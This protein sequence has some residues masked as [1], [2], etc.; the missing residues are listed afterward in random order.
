[1][2]QVSKQHLDGPFHKNDQHPMILNI[3]MVVTISQ[4]LS[5]L[6][7]FFF[8]CFGTFLFSH[9]PSFS[10]SAYQASILRVKSVIIA[11]ELQQHAENK[12]KRRICREWERSSEKEK[13]KIH[14]KI[15][16][17]AIFAH[18]PH[19][20][21]GLVYSKSVAHNLSARWTHTVWA[22]GRHDVFYE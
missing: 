17:H 11:L 8:F 9:R 15:F 3:T 7:L 14:I 13:T 16:V 21:A 6:L 2:N 5:M 18:K 20:S 1:M 4:T 10:C 19:H 22:F 12:K